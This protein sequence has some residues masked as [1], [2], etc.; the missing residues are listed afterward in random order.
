LKQ[1]SKV[2]SVVC[3][4]DVNMEVHGHRPDCHHGHMLKRCVWK[5]EKSGFKSHQDLV[6]SVNMYELAFGQKL[7]FSE[8]RTYLQPGCASPVW[9][10]MGM[11]NPLL[12]SSSGLD[13][14]H[15]DDHRHR[16]AESKYMVEPPGVTG[17]REPH[18]H[19]CACN[20][21]AHPL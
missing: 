5:R 10:A 19:L 2:V 7:R 4:D 6:E 14:G 3:F 11:K 15:D 13:T 18:G 17:R 16:V 21:E 20:S 12:G 8:K 9:Q 1:M